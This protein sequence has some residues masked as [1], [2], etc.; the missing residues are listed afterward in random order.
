MQARGWR[1]EP[2]RLHSIKP[3]AVTICVRLFLLE[4]CKPPLVNLLVNHGGGLQRGL[5]PR[6]LFSSFRVARLWISGYIA[7]KEQATEE[8]SVGD[9]WRGECEQPAEDLLR[10]GQPSTEEWGSC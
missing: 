6:S 10:C 7:N 3:Y 1:F 8:G 2:A 9:E 5:R 4:N